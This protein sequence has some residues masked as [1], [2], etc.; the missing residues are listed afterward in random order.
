MY[1]D[2]ATAGQG[3]RKL[4]VVGHKVGVEVC[5]D[6]VEDDGVSTSTGLQHRG[7]S[8]AHAEQGTPGTGR[9]PWGDD[10]CYDFSF[11]FLHRS[12]YALLLHWTNF[13][14]PFMGALHLNV[15]S[16]TLRHAWL[17]SLHGRPLTSCAVHCTT[18][19]LSIAQTTYHLYP[20]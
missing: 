17:L 9:G 6:G 14:S 20:S 1:N 15:A 11:L 12:S 4:G 13:T 7:G 3:V 8:T 2:D 18:Y 10:N 5:E 19:F 16:F